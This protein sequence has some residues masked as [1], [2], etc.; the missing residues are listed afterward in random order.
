MTG[1]VKSRLFSGHELAKKLYKQVRISTVGI[2]VGMNVQIHPP[3]L[4]FKMLPK[5]RSFVANV[6]STINDHN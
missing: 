6:M 5:L 1:F 2:K 3:K 4:L